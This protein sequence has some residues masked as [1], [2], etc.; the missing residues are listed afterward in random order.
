MDRRIDNDFDHPL[1]QDD[2]SPAPPD[3]SGLERAQQLD[4]YSALDNTSAEL[5]DL[6]LEAT[7]GQEH[8]HI[9]PEK[10]TQ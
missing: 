6:K 1:E 5:A 7:A 8:T 10:L 3:F 2:H 4:S 9:S